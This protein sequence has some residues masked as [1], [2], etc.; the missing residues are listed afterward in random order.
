VATSRQRNAPEM[1]FTTKMRGQHKNWA[2]TPLFVGE[3]L[4][5]GSARYSPDEWVEATVYAR[6]HG[7]NGPVWVW[8]Q[9]PSPQN[10][11][12]APATTDIYGEVE[13]VGQE[14]AVHR[15]T[16]TWDGD[17]LEIDG[18]IY[19]LGQ[20]KKVTVFS[21]GWAARQQPQAEPDPATSQ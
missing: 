20:W 9:G 16:P 1:F 18:T 2:G 11:S 17:Q 4:H 15:G 14:N 6:G 19:P 21:K 13:L 5:I 3:S 7:L 10:P 12:P 8:N